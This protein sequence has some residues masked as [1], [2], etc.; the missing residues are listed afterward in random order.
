L[1]QWQKTIL[2]PLLH[3]HL[4]LRCSEGFDFDEGAVKN[5][6]AVKKKNGSKERV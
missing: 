1:L 3:P 6:F 5:S 2:H 4:H